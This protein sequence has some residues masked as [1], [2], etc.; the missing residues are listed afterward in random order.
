MD[1]QSKLLWMKDI[2]EHIGTCHDQW[3]FADTNTER[4]LAESIRRDLDEMRRVCDSL[5]SSRQM[6]G[7][8]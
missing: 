2:L 1:R 7:S 5:C 3:Q 6:A 8:C 4:F